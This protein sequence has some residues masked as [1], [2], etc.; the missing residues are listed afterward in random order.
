MNK[1]KYFLLFTIIF[2]LTG[3]TEQNIEKKDEVPQ[4][5]LAEEK[6]DEY[7]EYFYE[8]YPTYRDRNE[9]YT[10]NVFL[11]T[12]KYEYLL[13]N[14]R[15]KMGGETQLYLI[16]FD[17]EAHEALDIHYGYTPIGQ[18]FT[19]F[20]QN[21]G[22]LKIYFGS[23]GA[24]LRLNDNDGG[25][26]DVEYDTVEF[27]GESGKTEKLK[28]KNNSGFIFVYNKDEKVKNIIVYDKEGKKLSDLSDPFRPKWGVDN[29]RDANIGD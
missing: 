11:S 26:I 8:A 28:T 25:E 24:R 12:D 1:L 29:V 15:N 10:P 16:I 18:G 27:L 23:C 20:V 6:I 5:Q 19:S 21:F 13:I 4:Y 9:V 17:K 22:D 2:L 3:C 14:S 7:I